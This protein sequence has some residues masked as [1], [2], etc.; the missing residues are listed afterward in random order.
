MRLSQLQA[1]GVPQLVLPAVMDLT[2]VP[3]LQQNCQQ[4]LAA[5]AGLI[6]DAAAVSRISSPCLEMLV[7]AARNFA[8]S[9]GPGLSFADASQAMRDCVVRLGLEAALPLGEASN[10]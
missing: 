3:S 10:D 6:I 8:A 7:V 1:G 2:L 9:G 5:G 4:A